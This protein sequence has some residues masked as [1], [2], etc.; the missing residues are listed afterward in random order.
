MLTISVVGTGHIGL[1]TG[2]CLAQLG[3]H[4]TCLDVDSAS[5]DALQR[6][7]VPFF[8]PGL[9]ELVARNR[10]A[11]RLQFTAE[12]AVGLH[13]SEI[14]FIAVG[15]PAGDDGRV[16][17]TQVRAAAIEIGT[18]LDR[19]TIVVNKSTVPIETCDLVETIVREHQHSTHAVSVVSNPEFL[20]EGSAIADFMHPDRIVIGAEDKSA[21]AVLEE[22]YAPLGAPLI[23][24]DVRTAEMIKY[25][26]NAFLATKISLVNE[27]A[28]I[29]ERVGADIRDVV[30]GVG[31]DKR[32]GASFMHAGLGF[33]G[34]CLPKDL[35]ALQRIAESVDVPATVV[36]ATR[37]VNER[38][39]A[40]SVEKVR[41]LI[42]DL[43]GVRVALLGLSFKPDTDDVR[44]SPAIALAR[45]LIEA[46]AGVVA[47]DPVATAAARKVCGDAMSYAESAYEAAKGAD[48][49]V[50][51]TDWSEYKQMD[52]AVLKKQ[53][54]RACIFDARNIYDPGEA[55]AA[56]FSYQ[57]VGRS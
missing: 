54:R 36:A 47:H 26:A 30:L 37:A 51:A 25:A 31:S 33:G 10:D 20:R 6:G 17:L 48:V 24:T 1:V 40:R 49:L 4:V 16:D 57:G 7:K 52:F 32:I 5:I 27:I 42:G 12:P 19:D 46:G 28:E 29:C 45:A 34:S 43:R 56:G 9:E 53:M 21:V 50:V 8:E 3:N 23:I 39:I 11:G 2:A 35:A 41:S 44:A 18:R 22:L 38:R 14:T 15:T 55:V 13:G